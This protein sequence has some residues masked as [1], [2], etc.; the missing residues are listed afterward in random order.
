MHHISKNDNSIRTKSHSTIS[1]LSF[2]NY[3]HHRISKSEILPILNT[4]FSQRTND[5]LSK[6][7]QFVL[8]SKMMTKFIND[9]IDLVTYEKIVV[10]SCVNISFKTFSPND[11]IYKANDIADNFYLILSGEVTLQNVSKKQT[12]MTGYEYYQ[13][14]KRLKDND[15]IYLIQRSLSDNMSIYPFIIDDVNDIELILLKILLYQS[16]SDT[17]DIDKILSKAM[18]SYSFFDIDRDLSDEDRAELTEEEKEKYL[19]IIKSKLMMISSYTCNSAGYFVNES[20][21]N[22]INVYEYVDTSIISDDYYFGDFRDERFLHKAIASKRTNVLVMSN[23]MYKEFI[24]KEK[25]RKMYDEVTFLL[26]NFFFGSI[27]RSKF[28]KEYFDLFHMERITKGTVLCEEDEKINEIYFIKNGKI[29]IT[30]SR[31][32]LDN[33]ILINI[34]RKRLKKEINSETEKKYNKMFS[35]LSISNNMRTLKSE[36]IKKTNQIVMLSENVQCLCFAPFAYGLSNIYTATVS[37]DECE[38]YRLSVKDLIKILKDKND[39]CFASF[40]RK[41]SS[42]MI[43]MYERLIGLNGGLIANIDKEYE[44]KHPNVIKQK[45]E[46]LNDSPVKEK[47]PFIEQSLQSTRENYKLSKADMIRVKKVNANENKSKYI[48]LQFGSSL[49]DRMIKI[50]KRQCYGKKKSTVN[51]NEVSKDNSFKKLSK[52]NSVSNFNYS[53]VNSSDFLS[54]YST[55]KNKYKHNKPRVTNEKIDRYRIFDEE[56]E[57][58]TEN[59]SKFEKFVDDN[60]NSLFLSE[61]RPKKEKILAMPF[62]VK[63]QKHVDYIK[64][65]NKKIN[66]VRYYDKI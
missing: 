42:M 13:Y 59:E 20:K 35:H 37:S 47:F 60:F 43:A 44:R 31:S 2:L 10:L 28:Q 3:Q 6:L 8:K 36:L 26:E 9:K 50:L 25:R 22:K 57:K 21:K 52:S 62:N 53:T 66:T 40:K 46:N 45:I 5:E 54:M 65:I 16:S 15:D 64:M 58:E 7:A 18:L 24:M 19:H 32:V 41:S 48:S 38:L 39:K 17:I 29:T 49:E 27:C 30:S 1:S 34:L 61:V 55:V 11:I 56:K 33:H 63:Q 14:I 4:P 23:K 51:S 12:S